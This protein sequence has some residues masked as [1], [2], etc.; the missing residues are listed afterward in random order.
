MTWNFEKGVISFNDD[1]LKHIFVAKNDIS[2]TIKERD[3]YRLK[4]K[5]TFNL[6]KKIKQSQ[7]YG[8][9][10]LIELEKYSFSYSKPAE[11]LN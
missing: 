4:Q 6:L 5:S 3:I 10:L 9:S 8:K 7:I 1:P 11:Y 2:E